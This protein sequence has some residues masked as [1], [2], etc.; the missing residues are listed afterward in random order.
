ME[1]RDRPRRRLD[2]INWRYSN[3]I[4]LFL[5][6]IMKTEVHL[7]RDEQL[8]LVAIANGGVDVGIT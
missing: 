3:K 7:G 1:I 4:D 5:S 6:W 2:K 8:H